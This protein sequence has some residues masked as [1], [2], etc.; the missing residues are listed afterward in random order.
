VA[1]VDEVRR[2]LHAYCRLLDERDLDKLLQLVYLPDAIDDRKRGAPLRGHAQLHDYFASAFEHVAATA[3][4]LSNVDIDIDG[5]RASAY[6]RVTAYHWTRGG[7]PVR[8]A[9]FV[10]LG[11]YDDVLVRTDAGWRIA[12]RTVSALGRAGIGQGVLPDVFAG[13]GGAPGQPPAN[14]SRT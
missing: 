13:F 14:P 11:S 5:N 3:H 12:Q 9:D 10:L 4:L 2:T 1:E 7:D 6:S 8:A